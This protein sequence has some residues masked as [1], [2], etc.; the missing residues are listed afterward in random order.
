MLPLI[1][2]AFDIDWYKGPENLV[3]AKN[4]NHFDDNI[5][6]LVSQLEDL[7]EG[8][9]VSKLSSARVAELRGDIVK[10]RKK[11]G[12]RFM[13]MVSTSHDEN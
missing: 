5:T 12:E 13:K 11:A 2:E 7:V 3:Y 10:E 8:V 6:W 4:G 1:L 9:D